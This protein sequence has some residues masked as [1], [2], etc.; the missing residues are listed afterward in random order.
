MR[1]NDGRVV[2]NFCIQA[3]AG[4]EV[5]VYGDGSQTRS[6]CY[7]DDLVDGLLR[8]LKSDITDP[9]NLGNPNEITI[10]EF[11]KRIVAMA[12]SKSKISHLPLPEDDPKVRKPDITRA[13]SLLGWSPK[14]DLEEGLRLTFEY[15]KKEVQGL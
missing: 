3:L 11:A 5:T 10:L 4:N 15:F 12:G 7:V 6:F 8:L 13:K 1:T 9:V 2:P 14:M